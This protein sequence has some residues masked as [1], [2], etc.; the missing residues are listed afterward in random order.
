M[1]SKQQKAHP[2]GVYIIPGDFNKACLKT[3]LPKFHQ[4]IKC[5]TRGN[6][7][8]D[9]VYS[10][11]KHAY[12]ATPLSHLRQSD[13]L[14]LLLF[15]AY[16]PLRRQTKPP[17]QTIKALPENALAQLKDCFACAEWSIFEHQDL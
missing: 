6:S 5:E 16:T 14:S 7:T 8:L 17:S 12:R 9:H 4:Y 15:P 2:D 1:V 3:V 11:F 13:H 10:N